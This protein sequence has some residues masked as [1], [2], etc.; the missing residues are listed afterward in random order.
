MLYRLVTF[1]LVLFLCA[2][3][4]EAQSVI[5]KWKTI[6][7]ETDKPKSIVE[8]FERDGK[9]YGRIESLFREPSEEQDPYCDVCKG[10]KK[11]QRVITMEIV[12]DMTQDGDEYSGGTITDP[13]TGKVYDC[14]LWLEGEDVLKVRGYLY[15]LFRTQTWYR[16]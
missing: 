16:E 13:K 6:D 1:F 3:N 14:K 15:F 12:E 8:I 10:D 2:V 4:I 5:G 9:V 7:D 11:D